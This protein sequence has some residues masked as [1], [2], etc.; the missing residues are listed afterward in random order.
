MVGVGTAIPGGRVRSGQADPSAPLVAP[1]CE[2][3]SQDVS[4]ASFDRVEDQ[5]AV[6]VDDLGREPG[7]RSRF[8]V[9]GPFLVDPNRLHALEAVRVVD[10]GVRVFGYRVVG[11]VPSH[12]ELGRGR[13]DRVAVPR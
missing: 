13:G 3:A 8:G 7:P 4:A 10:V 1:L 5:A 12:P 6:Q 11:C 2:P 9:E